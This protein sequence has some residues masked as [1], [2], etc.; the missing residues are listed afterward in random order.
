MAHATTH[1]DI[2][3]TALAERDHW[4]CHPCNKKVRP[5]TRRRDPLGPSID[6]LIP[7]HLGGTHTWNNVAL[8]HE[9]CNLSKG[10]RAMGEQLML[11]G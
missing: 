3:R 5:S 4:R 7:V 9:R 10:T 1:G 8:A 6:H 2:T 11:I